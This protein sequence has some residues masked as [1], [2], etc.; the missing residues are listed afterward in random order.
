MNRGTAMIRFATRV[1][2]VLFFA[3][4]LAAPRTDNSAI[5][6]VWKGKMDNLPL[7]R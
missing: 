4:A 7:F 6:G 5:V 2:L 3:T 1:F